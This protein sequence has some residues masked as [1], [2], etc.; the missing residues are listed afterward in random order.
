LALDRD[1]SSSSERAVPADHEAERAVLSAILLDH[2]AI[3]KVRDRVTDESFDQPRHRTI[4]RACTELTDKQVAVTLITLRSHL[5]EHGLLEQVGGVSALAEIADAVPTAAH[6][7]HHAQI[8]RDRG[9]A[10]ALIRT[11]EGIASRGYDREES[12][13]QLMEDAERQVMSLAMGHVSIDFTGIDDELHGTIEYIRRLNSG[14]VTGIATGF[15]GFDDLTGGFDGG[16]LVILAARPSMGKTALALNMARNHAVD[17]G[18]CVAFFSLEMTKRQLALRLIM[19]E[20]ELDLGRLRKAVLSDKEMGRLQ[21]ASRVL[22]QARIFIDDSGYLTSSDIAAKCRRLHR[23]QGLSLIVVDYIQLVAGGRSGDRREQ[24]VAEI[25]RSLKLLAK[26]LDLP[27]L[28]LSQLNRGPETR[29]N[30]RPLLADLRESGAIEQ[31]ADI[32]A[33]IYRD[34]V[35]DEDSPDAGLAEIIISKQRNGPVGTTKLQFEGRFARFN[36]LTGREPPP[37]SAGF[38]SEPEPPF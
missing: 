6:V 2:E 9:L 21:R 10:R 14:E 37:P 27:I 26:D 34:D 28:A 24:E 36:N 3:W 16:D 5:E 19:S 13:A 33:F 7:E 8:V 11:C 15:D 23:D 38:G 25:S 35:Y 32:V 31:D 12:V 1:R 4:Y 29:P 17:A 20:A 30:K 18:G 22:E